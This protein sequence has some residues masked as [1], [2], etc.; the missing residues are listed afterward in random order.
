MDYTFRIGSGLYWL[1]EYL[2]DTGG[3]TDFTNYDYN[4][5]LNKKALP[6]GQVLTLLA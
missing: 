4:L 6:Y 5:I 2:Y 3:D 1:S